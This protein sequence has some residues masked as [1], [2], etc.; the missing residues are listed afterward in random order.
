MYPSVTKVQRNLQPELIG[1]R[2][3]TPE[4]YTNL[5][6]RLAHLN[7]EAKKDLECGNRL[8]V[9]LAKLPQSLAASGCWSMMPY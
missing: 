5:N 7:H 4:H 1:S 6:S 8:L 9:L 3:S 2:A